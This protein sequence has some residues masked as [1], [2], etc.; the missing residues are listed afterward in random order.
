MLDVVVIV[1]LALAALCLLYAFIAL[2][3][4]YKLDKEVKKGFESANE[5]AGA[6]SKTAVGGAQREGLAAGVQ[7]QA[8]FGGAAEYLKALGEFSTGLSKLRQGI[9]ALVL[10]LAFALL[11][12]VAAGV[13]DKVADSTA[14]IMTG[15]V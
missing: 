5:A 13:E 4:D 3:Q 6:A 15:L 12:A 1:S 7:P 14:M 11:A 10:A 8:A 2:I 9:A